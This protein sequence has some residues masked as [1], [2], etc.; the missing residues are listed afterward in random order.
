MEAESRDATLLL[1]RHGETV[2]NDEGR[3]Q[4]QK[5]SPLTDRGRRQN[6]LAAE[7]LA[8]TKVDALYASDLGRAR[9]TAETI[10]SRLGIDIKQGS[11][12]RERNF[13]VLEG[14]TSDEAA[15]TQGAWFLS[16]QADRLQHAPPAGESQPDMAQRVMQVL[17]AIAK[18]HPGQTV[19]VATHGGPIKSAIYDI[20]RI[21]LSLWGL[22]W[23][24]NG[25][26][27]T[28]KGTPDV[29]RV[30][31]LNDTCHLEEAPPTPPGMED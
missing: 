22:T 10:A 16:W 20:L 24:A 13:G 29:F 21:P 11:A 18:A 2:W 26:I 3:V 8:R 31:C 25:S 23:V 4:G 5:N 27:T 6:E 14:Q 9:E 19:A 30:A 1:V 12:L 7:R 17:R 15:R 28:I